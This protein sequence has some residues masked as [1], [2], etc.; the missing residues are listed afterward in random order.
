MKTFI[1]SVILLTS[2]IIASII[3]SFYAKSVYDDFSDILDKM[4]GVTDPQN[5]TEY[6]K[7]IK[8]FAEGKKNYLYFT[9]PRASVND[10][11]SELEE[12]LGYFNSDDNASYN[13]YLSRIKLH[14][15]Q[16]RRNEEFRF[17]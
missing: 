5:Q 17:F 1:F 7:N 14:V 9:L 3:N 11:Y 8:S 4:P 13:A 12:M 15:K 16:L 2:I 10:F 6:S